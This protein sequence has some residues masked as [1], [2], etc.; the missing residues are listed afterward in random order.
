MAPTEVRRRHFSFTL[1]AVASRR[2][3]SHVDREPL[4]TIDHRYDPRCDRCC[5]SIPRRAFS[6]VWGAE[7]GSCDRKRY[8][9]QQATLRFKDGES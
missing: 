8:P 2:L 5:E 3:F 1:N 4:L 9:P 6:I 7:T